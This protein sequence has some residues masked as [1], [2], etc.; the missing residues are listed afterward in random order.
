MK[1]TEATQVRDTE[2]D[3]E[4]EQ[5]SSSRASSHANRAASHRRERAGDP[6]RWV[7]TDVRFAVPLGIELVL[8]F[9]G[10][11]AVLVRRAAEGAGGDYLAFARAAVLAVA[12]AA[13]GDGGGGSG[14]ESPD[15]DGAAQRAVP[16]T[17]E[18]A[19][20]PSVPDAPLTLAAA[21]ARWGVKRDRLQ[22][23]AMEGRLPA[24]KVGE[25]KSCPWLVKPMDVVRFITESRRGP[26]RR[27][28]RPARA[29]ALLPPDTTRPPRSA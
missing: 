9:D 28:G 12:R 15:A 23:A 20:G 29:A 1:A 17:I 2:T 22:R 19:S 21:A 14:V 6:R 10:D 5:G 27:A 8:E 3:A 4:R 13:V 25:G 11:D 18:P 24:Q 26:K 7:D 16:G